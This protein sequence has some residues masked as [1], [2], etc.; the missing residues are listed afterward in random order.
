MHINDI[1]LAARSRWHIVTAA[2][3][4]AWVL[5]GIGINVAGHLGAPVVWWDL[6][7]PLTIGALTTAVVVFST[8][9]TEALTRTANNGYRGVG[10][11]VALIQVGLILL[12]IDRAGYDWGLLADA[13]SLL[14]IAALAWQLAFTYT[15][16]R[17]SLSGSF[18]V[19]VPFYA[20]ASIFMIASVV[21]VILSGNG[22]G[23]YSFLVAA[24]SRGMVWGF[25]WLTIVG[26]IVTLLPTLSSTAIS[27]TARTRCTRGLIVHC[28]GLALTMVCG[29]VGWTRA[30]GIAQLLVV[31]AAIMIIQP[32]LATVLGRN[33]RL[34]TA[35]VSVIAGL[36]W[37]VALCAGDAVAA[38]LGA[39]PRVITLFLVSAFIGGGVLQMVTGV[40]HHLLP[41]L[42]GGGP[43]KVHHGRAT[44]DR[45][46][47]AR[48]VL[49]NLGALLSLVNALAAGL[50]LMGIGLALNV[51]AVGRAVYQ[52]QNLE[53]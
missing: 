44:A 15:R 40:L 33:P 10:A 32:V 31:L 48:L 47:F 37:M 8:H 20:A 45:A 50:I 2:L 11:R 12:I 52:Q 19:T 42:V 25:A 5:I 1:S 51:L 35:S 43:A 6:I 21:L 16:L 36:L 13:A 49:I 24:H 39:Y 34:T 28:A 4:G 9:F 30:A 3:I 38:A 18:A 22:V 17:G 53:N 46:G 29:A 27:P 14:I 41:T 26:T 23:N 7:H